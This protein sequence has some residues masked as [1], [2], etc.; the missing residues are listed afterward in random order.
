VVSG[1]VTSPCDHERI[2]SGLAIDRRRASKFSSF[3]KFQRPPG[4]AGSEKSTPGFVHLVALVALEV[5]A[6]VE[7][8]VGDVLLA[9]DDLV[10]VLALDLDAQGQS[11][12]LLDQH[13]EGLGDAGFEG[14]LA[15]DDGLVGLDAA[16]DVV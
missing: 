6:E 14:V 9:E 1:L 8:D 11:L 3:K 15:L 16:D 12:Q 4:P 5:D 10:L 13:P 7:W 2:I